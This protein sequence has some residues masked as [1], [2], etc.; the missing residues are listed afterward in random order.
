MREQAARSPEKFDVIHVE[1]SMYRRTGV[2]R[3]GVRLTHEPEN[4]ETGASLL[5]GLI[6]SPVLMAAERAQ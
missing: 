2:M 1:R 6:P 5:D 3:R 4:Q